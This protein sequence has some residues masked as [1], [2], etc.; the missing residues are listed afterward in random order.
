[1][2]N[3]LLLLILT[4]FTIVANLSSQTSGTYTYTGKPRYQIVTKKNGVFLSNI[5]IELYPNIAPKHTRNFDSLVSTHF[6]DSTVFHRVIPG[7]VIQ[8]GDPNSKHG[9]KS[10]WGYGQPWQPTVNAE[11]TAAKHLRGR[12]SAARDADINSANS[13]FFVCIANQPSL[14]NSYS[15]FG[16]VTSGLNYCDTIVNLPRDTDDIPYDTV[17][18]YISYLGS[19]DTVPNAPLLVQPANATTTISPAYVILK[20]NAVSDGVIYYLDLSTDPTFTTIIKSHQTSLLAYTY[21]TGMLSGTKYY[22]RVRVNNGGHFSAYSPTWDFTTTGT[23]SGIN[24]NL[25]NDNVISIYPNPSN[26]IFTFSNLKKGDKL[27]IQNAIGQIVYTSIINDSIL[28]VNLK[29]YEKGIYF[30]K[31]ENNSRS[32]K[33]GKII[34]N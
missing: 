31:I 3:K 10:T 17:R 8:G 19:N 30:Y 1:M 11:F 18:M 21:T 25:L 16:R 9:P 24:E 29:N 2:K 26:D 33:S 28:N 15:V 14:D 34:L 27:E 7:F 12:I 4:L 13:Q 20:W 32:L 23:A 6:F 22:W 5:N